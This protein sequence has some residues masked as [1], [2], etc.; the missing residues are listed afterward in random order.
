MDDPF[1]IWNMDETA[2][3]S[4]GTKRKV[5]MSASGRCDGTR[6][7][8]SKGTGKHV[9][10]MVTTSPSGKKI[11]PF[12]VVEGAMI[13]KRWFEPLKGPMPD[14]EAVSELQCYYA[15]GWFPE[16]VGIAVSESGSVTK[17]I[18]IKYIEHFNKHVRVLVPH[19]EHVLLLLDGHKSR[20]GIDWIESAMERKIIVAQ[21][22]ANTSHYLQAAD[23]DINKVLQKCGRRAKDILASMIVQADSVQFKFIRAIYGHSWILSETIKNSW[24]KTGLWPMDYRFVSI[25]QKMWNGRDSINTSDTASFNRVE[26]ESRE[27]DAATVNRIKYII[28]SDSISPERKVQNV[29]IIVRNAQTTNNILM[30]T[31][32]STQ[33]D[34]INSD[35]QAA[36]RPRRSTGIV[37][38][39]GAGT[40]ALYLTSG[41]YIRAIR[42]KEERKR[43]EEK[44][45]RT[46]VPLGRKGSC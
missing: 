10:C 16:D 37:Q 27:T 23:Q 30:N 38:Q 26:S 45:R 43:R 2:I 28:E 35:R 4:N 18:L 39:G 6:A 24:R 44:R 41:D 3:G 19:T 22:P 33:N 25:A 9:T 29:S 42:E 8:T 32:T 17:G 11:P 20:K 14:L 36:A 31:R 40:P 21:S 46:D 34:Q 13:M 7:S 15:N 5:L 12:L 1:K